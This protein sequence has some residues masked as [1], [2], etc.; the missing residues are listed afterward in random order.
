M[1][2][3]RFPLGQMQ[4]NC[5]FLIEDK[6]VLLIDPA[7]SA[8]FILEELSRRNLE[9]VGLVVTHGHFDHIMAV[10]EI[11][12]AFARST[13][14]DFLPLYIN[15]S[16]KFLVDRLVPT[17]KHFLGFDPAIIQPHLFKDLKVGA[18]Q[19]GEFKFDV[20]HTPGHTPGSSCLFFNEDN[21]L[22]TGDTL[23]RDG[24]GRYDFA[25]S[26]KIKLK[27]SINRIFEFED[28]VTIFPGHG[29]EAL[30]QEVRENRDLFFG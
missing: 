4:A 23:F 26:D 1:Q 2:L 27:A 5:Y 10:G 14:T 17:A 8:D 21:F 25:Y 6:K 12:L 16:D 24:V 22:F 3:I 15:M 20:I 30:I 29:E 28:E 18:H 13:D 7:D 9:L 11:Q 19:I